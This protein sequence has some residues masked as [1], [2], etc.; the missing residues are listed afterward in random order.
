MFFFLEFRVVAHKN[1]YSTKAIVVTG[2][3][4]AGT[5]VHS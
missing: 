2:Q 4:E 1:S 3:K 5:V